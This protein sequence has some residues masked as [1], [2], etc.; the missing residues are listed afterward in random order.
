MATSILGQPVTSGQPNR[1]IYEIVTE[2]IIGQLEQG[3]VPWHRPWA[4]AGAPVNLASGRPYRGINVM[5]LCCAGYSS[6]YWMTYRQAQGLGGHVRKGEKS[7]LVVFWKWLQVGVD[8]EPQSEEETARLIPFLRYYNVFN[9]EQID[10]IPA[11]KIPAAKVRI[12]EPI[13]AAQ[14]VIDCMPG[15]PAIAHSGDRAF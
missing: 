10:G 8:S 14:A 11:S 9:L 5:L 1:C 12:I 3:V 6:P 2:K 15:R 7:T 13:T 4:N